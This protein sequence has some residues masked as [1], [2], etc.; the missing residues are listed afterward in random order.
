MS[1]ISKEAVDGVWPVEMGEADIIQPFPSIL[2]SGLGRLLGT[3]YGLPFPIGF[4][5]HLATLP[6]PIGL[7]VAMF[8][9]SGFRRYEVTSLRVRVR[10]GLGDSSTAE[11]KLEE[12]DE[13][14]I[15]PQP[16]Q[17]F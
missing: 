10:R 8:F 16:G 4:L 13:V 7:A 15:A 17:A 12:L 14:Q 5:I 2:A 9:S 11:I 1:D 6:F 3:V